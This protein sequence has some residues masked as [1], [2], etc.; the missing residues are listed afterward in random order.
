MSLTG[1]GRSNSPANDMAKKW[2]LRALI[3]PRRERVGKKP[4]YVADAIVRLVA[5]LRPDAT[6]IGGGLATR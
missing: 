3:R 4:R 5:T 6:V 2:H 1:A